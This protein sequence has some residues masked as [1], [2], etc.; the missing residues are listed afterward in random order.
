MK[1][2]LIFLFSIACMAVMCSCS[3]SNTMPESAEPLREPDQRVVATENTVSNAV[4]E[5]TAFSLEDMISLFSSR[6]EPKWQYIRFVL[7]PDHAA[8]RVGAVLFWDS[9][10]ETS[11]VAFFDADGFFQ[12]CG[13]YAKVTPESGFTYLGNG[14][15]A[16]SAETVDGQVAQYTITLSVDGADVNFKVESDS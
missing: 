5:E 1:K 2:F 4:E 10:D 9:E 14:T 8:N 15:V 7:I 16:F 6:K 13:V 11:N 12:V 3:R